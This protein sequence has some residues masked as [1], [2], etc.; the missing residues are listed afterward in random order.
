[1]DKAEIWADRESIVHIFVN[2]LD[3]AIKY[4]LPGG[5]VEIT[6]KQDLASKQ[7]I[8]DIADTGIG[9]P[10][11]ARA[12]I[13]EPF[14]TVNK[15]RSRISGGTGLGLA[16]VQRLVEKHKGTIEM[17]DTESGTT[18]RLAFPLNSNP[19]RKEELS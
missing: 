11:D 14:F 10:E 1:M 13:F 9:I 5:K 18:F 17:P 15:D 2:L 7:A 19:L 12:H 4:N 8:V 3:N 16:L 6:C